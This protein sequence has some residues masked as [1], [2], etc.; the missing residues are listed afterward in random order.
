MIAKWT[1]SARF[2]RPAEEASPIIEG[3]AHEQ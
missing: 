3:K 2:V 1:Q